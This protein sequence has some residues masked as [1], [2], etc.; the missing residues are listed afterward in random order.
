MVPLR[1]ASWDQDR[2]PQLHKTIVVIGTYLTLP[3]GVITA[4]RSPS[5]KRISISRGR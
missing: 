4:Y 1:C 3:I 5:T 2:L